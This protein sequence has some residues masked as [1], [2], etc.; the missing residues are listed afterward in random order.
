MAKTYGDEAPR[1]WVIAVD[2]DEDSPLG[3]A[4]VH[5]AG[6]VRFVPEV[7]LGEVRQADYDAAV[8]VARSPGLERHLQVLQFGGRPTD[9]WPGPASFGS[10]FGVRSGSRAMRFETTDSAEELGVAELAARTVFPVTPRGGAYEVFYTWGEA[11][12]RHVRI[13]QETG[14]DATAAVAKRPGQAGREWWWLPEQTRSP[15]DWIPAIFAHWREIDPER[16]PPPQAD[17]AGQTEWMT[18]AEREAQSAVDTHDSLMATEVD[19]LLDRR[20]RLQ[21]ARAAA[22]VAADAAERRLLTTQGE[23]LVDEVAAALRELGFEVT[24]ADSLEQHRA[25]KQ[26]D[27]RVADGGWVCLAEV[28][29]YARRGAKAG[30]LLQLGK[31]V[32]Q[33]V[34]R[35]RQ[36]PDARWYVVNAP[37]DTPP[38]LRPRPLAGSPDLEVFAEAGGLIIDTRDLFRLREAVRGGDLDAEGARRRLR[39]ATGV[40]EYPE[41]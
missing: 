16:F 19:R 38:G 17:W 21:G 22:R 12:G 41:R 5:E 23:E 39:E 15:E 6:S 20:N 37:F 8:C 3:R 24:D 31:A 1:P 26:E 14:G 25:A 30:D 36:L 29:G 4:L 34:L 9:R 33:F 32:E 27:L 28:K 35:E 40:L 11:S 7:T 13:T 10:G 2:I 18:A